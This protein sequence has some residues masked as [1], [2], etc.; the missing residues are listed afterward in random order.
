[1]K[2]TLDMRELLARVW[3]E[4]FCISAADVTDDMDF[5][6]MGGSS[7]MLLSLAATVSRIA[8]VHL[9]VLDLVQNSKF[10]QMVELAKINQE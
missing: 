6:E 1:M 2:S 3:S 8:D 5:F 9:S 10:C 4:C 7:I